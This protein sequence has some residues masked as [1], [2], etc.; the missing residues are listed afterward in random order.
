MSVRLCKDDASRDNMMFW[1]AHKR[2]L[3]HTQNEKKKREH[4]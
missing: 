4:P 3:K 1:G 2:H